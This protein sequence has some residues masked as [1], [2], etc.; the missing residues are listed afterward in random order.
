MRDVYLVVWR[1]L[2]AL[3]RVSDVVLCDICAW[4]SVFC[5]LSFTWRIWFT[6]CYVVS[7]LSVTDWALRVVWCELCVARWCDVYRVSWH[8]SHDVCGV[9]SVVRRRCVSVSLCPLSGVAHVY[10]EHG[11][12]CFVWRII[13]CVLRCWS[14]VLLV[15]VIRVSVCYLMGSLVSMLHDFTIHA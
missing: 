13:Y 1:V 4:S 2:R 11:T 7:L 12:L 10:V 6:S 3:W 14:F 9:L 15:F 5:V 8:V